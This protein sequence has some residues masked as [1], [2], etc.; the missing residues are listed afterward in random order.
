MQHAYKATIQWTGN[1]GQGT[2]H[3]R[4]YDRSHTIQIDHKIDIP[5]SS[6][7]SYRGDPARHNPEEL[8]ISSLSACH[9]LWYLHLCAVNE[10]VVVAYTDQVS[11]RM[12]E[13]E[14]GSGYFTE[15]ILHPL[16]TV[17]EEAMVQKATD[18]HHQANKMCF[19]A[20]SVKCPVYHKPTIVVAPL[21]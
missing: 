17:M 1:L 19:I 9:M 6:D 4:A 8:F 11:G 2:R 13:T 15:V 12:M 20:N 5:G 18:L 16:V 21:T 3:Y 7:P 14:N 10:V